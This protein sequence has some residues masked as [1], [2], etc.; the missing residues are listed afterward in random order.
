MITCPGLNNPRRG[1]TILLVLAML[2]ILLLLAIAFSYGTRL[3]SQASYNYARIAQARVSATTGLPLASSMLREAS[4]GLT[5]PNQ[6][7]NI[8]PRAINDMVERNGRAAGLSAAQ[9]TMLNEA[10]INIRRGNGGEVLSGP[11]ATI[12]IRDLSG[13]VNLNAI[14]DENTMARVVQAVLPGGDIVRKSRALMVLKDQALEP[15]SVTRQPSANDT[16][17]QPSLDPRDPNAVLLDSLTRLQ[18]NPGRGS[19]PLFT[20][21]EI[22]KLAQFVTVFSQA[23]EVYNSP[24]GTH[25]PRISLQAIDP[26]I[27][28][29]RL[30]KA[31]PHKERNLL[32]QFAA[33][34]ADFSDE[35]DK[36]TILNRDGRVVD[37]REIAQGSIDNYIIGVEQ[38]PMISEVYPDSATPVQHG[39]AGQFVEIVNPWNR[40][41]NLMGWK[42]KTGKGTVS[43]TTSL[44]AGGVLVIT[45]NLNTPSANAPV[46]KGSLVSIFGATPDGNLRKAMTV[47]TLDLTDRNGRVELYN[48]RNELVDVFS[49][50]ANNEVDGKQSFQRE[51]PLVRGYKVAEA[52]PFEYKSGSLTSMATRSVWDDGNTTMTKLSQLFELSTGFATQ[53]EFGRMVHANQTAALTVPEELPEGTDPYPNNM[54]LRLIDIFTVSPP[55]TYTTP[56]ELLATE[57]QNV[58]RSGNDRMRDFRE[59]MALIREGAT[60]N[61]V[62]GESVETTVALAHSYGKINVNT[63]VK[64]ALL[65]L[66]TGSDEQPANLAGIMEKFEAHRLHRLREQ[67]AP[68][69]NVSEFLVRFGPQFNRS[70]LNE[71]DRL[72]DQVSVGSSAFEV[73]AQN[74][75]SAAEQKAL[76]GGSN[77]D[78]QRPATATAKW[79]IS[80][81]QEPYSILDYTLTP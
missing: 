51:D 42:L 6:A 1:A 76:E 45:D 39:D 4:A 52:T 40:N 44:P 23:P 55:D 8:V 16:D 53:G 13:L 60:Y 65:A 7:W 30:R 35:D 81:D 61:E 49:Y 33:N 54:D 46:G 14:E 77:I 79:I 5:T 22:Q 24:D 64:Q 17:N 41:L 28:F 9:L 74:R 43:L 38:V 66:R 57:D 63:C 50:G 47:E 11:Q 80:M 69:R 37:V 67:K 48:N 10:G 68:F 19:R 26:E 32:L 27:V 31:F 58:R 18:Y 2:S 36:P 75:L 34:V 25:I 15:E 20:T 72:T 71:L 29:E 59:R 62:N 12:T 73:V 70:N 56:T 78:G 21:D 3:E